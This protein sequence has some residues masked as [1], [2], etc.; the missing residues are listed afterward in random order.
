MLACAN[1]K[2]CIW[3]TTC[4][5]SGVS[6]SCGPVADGLAL[7]MNCP[8]TRAMMS[9]QLPQGNRFGP[10]LSRAWVGAVTSHQP[11]F[12]NPIP[13]HTSYS[14][15]CILRAWAQ[16]PKVH[17]SPTGREASGLEEFNPLL[18]EQNS[19]LRA[20]ELRDKI[21]R[22]L[23]EASL[24]LGSPAWNFVPSKVPQ[25]CEYRTDMVFERKVLKTQKASWCSWA[26]SQLMNTADSH[27][28]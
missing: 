15:T 11:S 7:W 9:K 3:W 6:N 16:R 23:F 24:A 14:S 10:F 13:L 19:E 20:Q 27:E 12:T 1:L 5:P 26:F 8:A 2:V 18:F 22:H 25:A 21:A 4:V 17:S 28:P